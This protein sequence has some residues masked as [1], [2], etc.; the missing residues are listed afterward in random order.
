MIKLRVAS[1]AGIAIVTLALAAVMTAQLAP[2]RVGPSAMLSLE[3]PLPACSQSQGE[4]AVLARMKPGYAA[5]SLDSSYRAVPS[6]EAGLLV[7]HSA[8]SVDLS[9]LMRNGA[10]LSAGKLMAHTSNATY[11]SCFYRLTDNPKAAALAQSVEPAMVRSGL[12]TQAQFDDPS[13]ILIVTDDPTNPSHLFVAAVIATPL[14]A[15]SPGTLTAVVATL[16][17]TSL[18]ELGVGLGHWYD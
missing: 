4:I 16:D 14:T 6:T 8:G 15:S 18:R 10:V 17:A 11:R 2:T 13:T 9:A 12:I 7:V 5:S 3:G 1:L